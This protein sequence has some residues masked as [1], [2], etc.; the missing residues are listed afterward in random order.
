M[1]RSNIAA[2]AAPSLSSSSPGARE[3]AAPGLLGL[4]VMLC[5]TFLVVLDFFIVNVALP[6]MQRELR[7]DAATLQLVVAGYGLATAAGLV[8]GGRLGDMFGRR[9]MFMLGLLLFTLASAACGLAPD[10][11]LLVAARVLQGLAGALLQPQVLAMIGLAY[12]GERRARAFAA[13]GIALGL[14]ATLGQLVGGVLIDVDPAGLGW[15]SCFLIN[16]PIGLAAL[17]LAPRVIPPLANAGSRS[18][19][20]LAGMLLLAAGSIAVVLPLGKAAS[21]A[22]RCGA[23][24]AWPPRCRSSRSSRCSSAAWPHAAARRCWRRPCWPTRASSWAC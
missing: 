8:T 17:L 7:A 6:S 4:G 18:R 13:Y 3:A 19:L 22:G 23:G 21:R 24:S 20:D 14:A 5:G 11:G 9:R 16:L 15:R 10:A 2:S 1:T 12:T